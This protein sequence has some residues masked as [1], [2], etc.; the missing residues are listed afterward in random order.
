M[1]FAQVYLDDVVMFSRSIE[2]HKKNLKI[3]TE[4]L[5]K[6]HLKLKIKKCSFMHE[7]IELSGHFIDAS[8]VHL[9]GR[10]SKQSKISQGHRTPQT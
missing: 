8:G 3:V 2:E 6:A 7:K 9:T 10:K 5:T 4:R 1:K